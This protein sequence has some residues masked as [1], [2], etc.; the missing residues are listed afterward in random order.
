MCEVDLEKKRTSLGLPK[1]KVANL[2]QKGRGK[3][4]SLLDGR[5]EKGPRSA[6]G[7]GKKKLAS[8]ESEKGGEKTT[9]RGMADRRRGKGRGG[10]NKGNQR[11]K[12]KKKRLAVGCYRGDG[13]RE[14]GNAH[15][16]GKRGGGKRPPHG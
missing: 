7:R 1:G 9:V 4:K 5:R 11:K 13:P 15:L 16:S 3:K 8:L 10:G 12:K 2:H 14:R 6:L